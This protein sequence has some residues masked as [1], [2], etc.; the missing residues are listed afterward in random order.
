VAAHLEAAQ[1]LDRLDRQNEA[2][3]QA[4][5]A[6]ELKPR[7]SNM[8]FFQGVLE[9]QRADF[10]GAVASQTRSIEIDESLVALTERE[11]CERRIGKN[12]EADVDLRRIQELA[13]QKQ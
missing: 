7:D 6:T 9:R 2:L 13:P 5:T 8:W 11:Q 10:S 12:A 3:F 1:N 4:R